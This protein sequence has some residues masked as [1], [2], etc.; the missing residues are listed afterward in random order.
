MSY[1]IESLGGISPLHFIP[2]A[3]TSAYGRER[4]RRKRNEKGERGKGNKGMTT[5]VPL[6]TRRF[7]LSHLAFVSLHYC[8]RGEWVEFDTCFFL[9][10]LPLFRTW[11]K[12]HLCTAEIFKSKKSSNFHE[13]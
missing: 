6:G 1:S 5:V 10:S 11:K 7:V 2:I 8:C 12:M 3:V 9:P 13:K 4:R